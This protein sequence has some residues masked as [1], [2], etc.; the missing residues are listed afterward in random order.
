[1]L[2]LKGVE[3]P[4]FPGIVIPNTPPDRQSVGRGRT[5][6]EQI[7]YALWHSSIDK[8]GTIFV[9]HSPGRRDYF[10]DGGLFIDRARCLLEIGELGLRT[11]LQSM[12]IEAE[13]LA[14]HDGATINYTVNLAAHRTLVARSGT[15]AL[16]DQLP[17]GRR[18]RFGIYT[19]NNGHLRP[20]TYVESARDYIVPI[21]I[22]DDPYFTTHDVVDHCARFALSEEFGDGVAN[23]ADYVLAGT[24]LGET[25]PAMGVLAGQLDVVSQVKSVLSLY[26][27]DT[28][29][30]EGWQR[31][32]E[33]N[34]STVVGMVERSK[35]NLADF[36]R[37]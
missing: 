6:F 28:Q 36:G 13:R 31:L 7:G 19:E 15:M 25:T 16:A 11:A 20:R 4:G 35:Q 17:S 37:R 29:Q 2:A 34:R 8:P 26:Q 12:G 21:G 3:A 32:L 10:A 18:T 1:M 22:S 27:G 24:E 30:F 9:E 33:A 14:T 23:K 5:G